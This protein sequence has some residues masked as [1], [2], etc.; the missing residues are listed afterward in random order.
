MSI[1]AQRAASRAS[2]TLSNGQAARRLLMNEMKTLDSELK[3]I[4]E[5]YGRTITNISEVNIFNIEC[6]ILLANSIYKNGKFAFNITFP[7]LYPFEPPKIKCRTKIF[8]PNITGEDVCLNILRQEF[9][10]TVYLLDFA[11]GLFFFLININPNDFL[12]KKAIK[13]YIKD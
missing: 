4:E 8:H 1:F 3:N 2:T 7:D 11:F 12:D 5:I 10:P 13:L 9:N 6:T